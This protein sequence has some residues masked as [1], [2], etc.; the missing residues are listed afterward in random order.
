M[1]V[2]NALCAMAR[3]DEIDADTP[4]QLLAV[5]VLLREL[6]LT[7]PLDFWDAY[8]SIIDPPLE[9]VELLGCGYVTPDTTFA[10]LG[11]ILKKEDHAQ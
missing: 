2:E 8:F 3:I 11:Q 1:T 10:E 5:T 7:A 9:A 6:L 4:E